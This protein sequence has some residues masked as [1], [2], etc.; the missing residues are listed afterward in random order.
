MNDLVTAVKLTVK[1]CKSED[2]KSGDTDIS[3]E[4]KM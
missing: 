1:V 4:S 2:C 3:W